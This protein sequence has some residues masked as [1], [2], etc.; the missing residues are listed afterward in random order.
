MRGCVIGGP[1]EPPV[2]I[3]M[4]LLHPDIGVVLLGL[5]PRW[6]PDATGKLLRRLEMA[7]FGAIFPGHLPVVHRRVQRQNLADLPRM[8]ADGFAGQPPIS[9]PEGDAWTLAVR[10]ALVDAVQLDPTWLQKVRGQPGQAGKPAPQPRRATGKPRPRILPAVA[11]LALLASGLAALALLPRQGGPVMEA[12]R[13]GSADAMGLVL[14]D[15]T[16]VPPDSGSGS[17]E[18]LTWAGQTA[19]WAGTIPAMDAAEAATPPATPESQTEALA[20]GPPPQGGMPDTGVGLGAEAGSTAAIPAS[21]PLSAAEPGPEGATSGMAAST[22][23]PAMAPDPEEGK[24][25]EVAAR[26]PGPAVEPQLAPESAT[27]AMGQDEPAFAAGSQPLQQAETAGI[28]H[29]ATA[30]RPGIQP[31][32]HGW[33]EPHCRRGAG[34][35]PRPGSSRAASGLGRQRSASQGKRRPAGSGGDAASRRGRHAGRGRWRCGACGGNAAGPARGAGRPRQR[36]AGIRGSGSHAR[37]GA[38]AGGHGRGTRIR[39]GT[40]RGS[41]AGPRPWSDGPLGQRPAGHGSRGH[42]PTGAM[43]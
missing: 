6:T 5:P 33:R 41:A 2:R 7:H 12:E 23:A 8:L 36:R 14:T 16:D 35:G 10:R 30:I 20:A 43:A 11:G 24:P 34:P 37:G 26:L 32:N 18:G 31:G 13:G 28:A 19:G 27:A 9:V 3:D 1:A 25:A 38:A 39:D 40:G 15:A 22:P 21:A 29:V 42:A 4:A 17:A